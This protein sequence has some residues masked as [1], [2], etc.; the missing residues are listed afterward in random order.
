LAAGTF[1]SP[2]ILMRSGIGPSQHLQELGIATIADLPVGDRLKDHPFFF[3]VYALRREANAMKPAAGALVWIRSQSTEPGD[4][5]LHIS[6]THIVDPNTSPAGGAIVLAC[7]V[8]LPKSIGRLRLSSRDP[9]AMPRIH[10]DFF[11][12]P[13]GLDRLEEAVRLSRQIGRTA[14]FSELIDREFAPG[15][16]VDEGK[17]IVATLEAIDR[18]DRS[19]DRSDGCR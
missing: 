16:T 7:A 10:Y 4:L 17:A 9:R 6:A 11:D 3:N 18:A 1:G 2:A 13:N 8:T 5:D 15:N 19:G 12:H 14:P